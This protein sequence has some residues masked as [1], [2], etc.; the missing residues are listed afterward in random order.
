MSVIKDLKTFVSKSYAVK[1]SL[2]LFM[3]FANMAA[4]FGLNMWI[5]EL[6]LRIQGRECKLTA[7]TAAQKTQTVQRLHSGGQNRSYIRRFP[8]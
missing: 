4:G 5:P 8:I 7:S 3:F 1:S 2:I 6:L